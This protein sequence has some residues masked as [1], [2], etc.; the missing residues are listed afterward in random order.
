MGIS[1][2]V[3]GCLRTSH[4]YSEGSLHVAC[5]LQDDFRFF[6]VFSVIFLQFF[7]ALY[8]THSMV[9]NV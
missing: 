1:L 3:T 6:Q 4:A 2:S 9:E 7:A 5:E 8:A